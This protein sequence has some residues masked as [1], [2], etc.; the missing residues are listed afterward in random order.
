MIHQSLL[1]PTEASGW[2]GGRSSLFLQQ[3]DIWAG[4]SIVRELSSRVGLKRPVM[5]T[6]AGLTESEL[7]LSGRR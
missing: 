4:V 5:W 7:A 1:S 3:E 6:K 2:E